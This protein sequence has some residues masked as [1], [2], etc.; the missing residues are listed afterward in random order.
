MRLGG[1]E[2]SVR[3]GEF[4]DIDPSIATP[5]ARS[6]AS[7]NADW[8]D[9]GF[10]LCGLFGVPGDAGTGDLDRVLRGLHEVRALTEDEKSYLRTLVAA[11]GHGAVERNDM[12][13]GCNEIMASLEG[14]GNLRETDRFG[15]VVSFRGPVGPTELAVKIAEVSDV[16]ATDED[17]LRRWLEDDLEDAELV[18]R[19]D[20]RP[21]HYLKG[22]RLPY[23]LIPYTHVG[24]SGE[25]STSWNLAFLQST[26]YLNERDATK[27]TPFPASRMIHV[28]TVKTAR[29]NFED[30][31][32]T[33]R[34]WESA[35]PLRCDPIGDV[36][37]SMSFLRGFL[38]LTNEIER[39]IRQTEIYPVRM[40]GYRTAGAYE[41]LSLEQAEDSRT[42]PMLSKDTPSLAAYLLDQETQATAIGDEGD[43]RVYVGPESEFK[44]E[45]KSSEEEWLFES[46]V[47]SDGILLRRTLSAG[48]S[49]AAVPSNGFLR[50]SGLTW[51]RILIER[52]ER[53]IRLFGSHLFLQRA[54]V[55]PD[56]V[57]MDTG[58][59]ELPL[60]ISD[61][62]FDNAKRD[63][64]GKIWRTRP[65]YCLQGPPG[66]G[67]TTLVAQLLRQIYETDA[68]C[69]VLLTAQAHSAV[70]HLRDEVSK[71]VDER[72]RVDPEWIAPIAVRLRR[73]NAGD[74]SNDAYRDPASPAAVARDM[75]AMIS[76]VLVARSSPPDYIREWL[77][78]DADEKNVGDFEQ[79]VRNSANFT[80]CSSTARDLLD[81]AQSNRT[82]D[83][84]IIEEAGRAHGFDL[85][86][87][88]QT[89]HR[90]LLI[91]DQEQLA[92]YRDKD[93]VAGLE[94]AD[95]ICG[96]NGVS[97]ELRAFWNNLSDQ[98]RRD[99]VIE[100]KRWLYFFRELY[101]TLRRRVVP[102][103]TPLVG[104]LTEQ[105]R[106]HPDIGDL[107]S[108][109][110]YADKVTSGTRITASGVP[111]TRVQHHLDMPMSIK[112]AAIVW[113]DVG[114]A[115]ANTVSGG[116]NGRYVNQ[117]E[118]EAV[119]RTLR[120]LASSVGFE[121]LR[122][123]T[124]L[125]TPYRKQVKK[126]REGVKV[127]PRW[128]KA[129][130]GFAHLDDRI[131]AFTVD[132]FQ[133]RQASVVVVSLVR[134][135]M[136]ADT[137]SAIGFLKEYQ[138]INVMVSRAEKL[139]VLVGS[140]DF[141]RAHLG[142]PRD[143]GQP[144]HELS[145][146]IGWLAEAFK[147]GRAVLVPADQVNN[148]GAG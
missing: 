121:G 49:V 98:E 145:K 94:R 53:A 130:E 144:F 44:I 85:V 18:L 26:Q 13:R 84:S 89:G 76:R 45:R 43:V 48:K 33:V 125:L 138:R 24:P 141:F 14:R 56:T 64:L 22:R 23:R 83:W 143:E 126:M 79:L 147:D 105:H 3:L 63:V 122:E 50:T 16:N 21:T 29:S 75:R 80:Y 37:P 124:A 72:R 10:V 6:N 104:M 57:Y 74:A 68:S 107:V 106:M 54:L 127:R 42:L 146:L 128:A 99:F 27:A 103:W 19:G 111:M 39:A 129:P 34:S 137:G 65:I 113:I 116:D 17:A 114:S 148:E 135:N 1:F 55:L 2:W 97:A 132:S 115:S 47:G 59:E 136:E 101:T 133:G 110:F 102:G 15:V 60:P 90:W 7:L 77:D 51:Q 31:S 11:R 8:R 38:Q 91:G 46:V 35:F 117:R 52:R 62:K 41:Y 32:A 20:E 67:K 5:L 70:D 82:F 134:N 87:P 120:S 81:L 131:G 9:L 142:E 95:E 119:E 30:I 86:L 118:I 96:A 69:Q 100:S 140:W 40:V 73:W 12:V 139:L 28:Y 109:A 25:S 92:P 58:M 93:F 36:H 71:F 88:L 108:H 4:A 112:G 123:T 78:G 61:A 66:T